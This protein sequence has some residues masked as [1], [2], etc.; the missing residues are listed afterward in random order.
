MNID[1][2]PSLTEPKCMKNPNRLRYITLDF[3]ILKQKKG[4]TMGKKI[5]AT[6]IRGMDTGRYFEDLPKFSRSF[7]IWQNDNS[8][9][10][11]AI[12]FN[13]YKIGTI[14]DI[15][16]ILLKLNQYWVI[17]VKS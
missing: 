9:F 7:S 13:F 11:P 10:Q 8:I 2:L 3:K 14:K 15:F 17:L 6:L 5:I 16:I 1:S 4:E 12:T